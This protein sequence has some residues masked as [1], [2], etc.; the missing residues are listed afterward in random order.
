MLQFK[1][2]KQNNIVHILDKREISLKSGKIVS[3]SFPTLEVNPQTGQQQMMVKLGIEIDGK[4]T[5]FSIPESSSVSHCYDLD[6]IIATD[7]S[8]LSREVELICNEA[9]QFLN[10]VESQIERKRMEKEKG[11]QLLA[12]LSPAFKEKQETEKRFNSIEQRFGVVEDS[13][14]EMRDMFKEFMQQVGG[15]NK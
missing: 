10:S 12:E 13:V 2:L 6:L 7:K 9:D 5:P 11:T 8:L 3:T 4:T 14:K 15:K 1:D